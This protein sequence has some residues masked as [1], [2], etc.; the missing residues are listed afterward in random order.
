MFNACWRL[1]CGDRY[2]WYSNP[3]PCYSMLYVI[4]HFGRFLPWQVECC[5]GLQ[6]CLGHFG[7]GW[8]YRCFTSCHLLERTI[9]E[10]WVLVAK[11]Q[12]GWQTRFVWCTLILFTSIYTNP[13]KLV[14]FAR[15][16]KSTMVSWRFFLSKWKFR[17]T[18]WWKPGKCQEGTIICFR[19]KRKHW[20]KS[21]RGD[22]PYEDWL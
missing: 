16:S 9:L 18:L 3:G 21:S 4:H 2:R 12:K 13:E 5:E 17:A 20:H 7:G 1:F 19:T 10:H 6:M 15:S 8:S 11:N 22:W 14:Y